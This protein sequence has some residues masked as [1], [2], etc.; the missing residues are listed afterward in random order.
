MKGFNAFLN[1]MPNVMR[2][3]M[4][5]VA[6]MP[7]MDIRQN[8]TDGGNGLALP[9]LTP[10]QVIAARPAEVSPATWARCLAALLADRNASDTPSRLVSVWGWAGFWS[11][12]VRAYCPTRDEFIAL[13]KVEI[14]VSWR[15]Y[16]QPFE[17]FVVV[18]PPGVFEGVAGS[19]I[20]APVAAVCRHD[21]AR[22]ILSIN[23]PTTR[24]SELGEDL[25]SPI[26]W[27]DSDRRSIEDDFRSMPDPS[28]LLAAESDILEVVKRAAVNANLLMTH[29][30]AR[31][32]GPANPDHERRL[33][34]SLAKKTLPSAVRAA[35][36]S[37]LRAMPVLYSLDQNVRV[38]AQEGKAGAV[39]DAGRPVRP[40]WRRGHWANLACGEGRRERR[41]HYRAAVMVHADLF[42]GDPSKTRV[43]YTT[44][45]TA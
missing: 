1:T 23:I 26:W 21:A 43:V 39:D 18:V 16:R 35:N 20:G 14:R 27:Q 29:Y 9:F 34:E 24:G 44:A 30:G 6:G 13:S 2:E 17:T 22:R 3:C 45:S 8:D 41:L 15:E 31:L 11:Q 28:D 7:F 37:A 10:Q 36:E 12:G 42:A 25:C 4:R 5:A 32:I 40:H 33:R 38:F 19:D